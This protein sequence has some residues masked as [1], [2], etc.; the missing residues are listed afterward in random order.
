MYSVGTEL[1]GRVSVSGRGGGC[2]LATICGELGRNVSEFG[3]GEGD[4]EF[5]S[6]G[7]RHTVILST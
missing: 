5:R 6:H 4:N 1:V 3:G 7:R 2:E